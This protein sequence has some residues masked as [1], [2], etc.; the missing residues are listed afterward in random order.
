M[1]NDFKGL[2]HLLNEI[3]MLS[4]TPRSGFAFLGTGKQSVAE[5]SYSMALLAFFLA[6]LS[7][8]PI[9]K[10]KLVMMCLFHDLPEARTGDLNYVNKIY[11]NACSGKAVEHMEEDSNSGKTISPYIHEFE[12]GKTPE[13]LL[14]HDADQLELMLVLKKELDTGN[15]RAKEWLEVV[16][17]RL[18]TDVGKKL[19]K[20]IESTPFDGWWISRVRN[21]SNPK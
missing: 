16:L 17:S 18:K 14:A 15:P 7:E 4:Q 19:A 11:A 20:E 12:E 21:R 1:K 10:Y 8:E 2:V 9:D 3:S 13:S 5:H 6:D